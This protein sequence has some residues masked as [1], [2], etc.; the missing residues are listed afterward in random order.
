MSAVT[1]LGRPVILDDVARLSGVSRATASRALGAKPGVADDVRLRVRTIAQALDYRPNRAAKNLAG[2]RTGLI[3]LLLGGTR[4]HRNPYSARLVDA[5]AKAAEDLDHGLLLVMSEREPGRAVDNLIR[6]R[7]V[8]GVL[9]S[10]MVFGEPWAEQLLDSDMTTVLIGGHPTRTDLG[11]VQVE[12]V[13]STKLLI[14]HLFDTGC[15]RIGMIT[16]PAGRVDDNGRRAGFEAAHEDRGVAV[17]PALIIDGDYQRPTG[18]RGAV[19]LLER[20]VDAIFAGNDNAAFGVLEACA[21]QGVS[22]PNEVSV[23][24]FDGASEAQP[25]PHE[26]TTVVQPYDALART[27]LEM[28]VDSR[29]DAELLPGHLRFGT[30]TRSRLA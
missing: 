25:Y 10:S 2:A 29:V 3:G 26:L 24:G 30:T 20:G 6:D 8:D 1:D 7:I 23:V 4:L 14:S 16:G 11:C 28:V 22:V 15:E 5:L 17:D 13:T 18:Y 21:D 9:V 19:A 12:N 27:T